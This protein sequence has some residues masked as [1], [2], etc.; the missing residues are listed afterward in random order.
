MNL[1][2]Y[3]SPALGLVALTLFSLS[4]FQK[5]VTFPPSFH[6][7]SDT[8]QNPVV[9]VSPRA[10]GSKWVWKVGSKTFLRRVINILM[11]TQ[12]FWPQN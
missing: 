4:S 10:L 12:E 6:P 2:T 1:K 7:A 8:R 5:R 9:A 11:G 3:K